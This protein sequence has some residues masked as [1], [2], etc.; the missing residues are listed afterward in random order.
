MTI[1]HD[2]ALLPCPFCGNAATLT[3]KPSDR[4]STASVCCNYADCIA[5]ETASF[6]GEKHEDPQGIQAASLAI[7]AWNRRAPIEAGNGDG[8]SDD[9]SKAPRDGKAVWL[10]HECGFMELAYFKAEAGGFW[11]NKYTA[12]PVQWK[13]R[14]WHRVPSPP[15]PSNEGEK[16]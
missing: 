4:Y 1:P 9:M 6:D 3:V 7:A 8:W 15:S 2:K 13:P 10:G 5:S 14:F 11:A 16:Q 12:L